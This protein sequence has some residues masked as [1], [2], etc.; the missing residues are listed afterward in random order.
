[1]KIITK[2]ALRALSLSI[3]MI[4]QPMLCMEKK[5]SPRLIDF[6]QNPLTYNNYKTNLAG[7]IELRKNA[8]IG[9]GSK[10]CIK[11]LK[12]ANIITEQRWPL[13]PVNVFIPNPTTQTKSTQTYTNWTL[14]TPL[15]IIQEINNLIDTQIN[16]EKEKIISHYGAEITPQ[17]Q[18]AWATF[19]LLSEQ[20]KNC[21]KNIKP[22]V[23]PALI[24]V[25]IL[26][27][28]AIHINLFDCCQTTLIFNE[29]AKLEELLNNFLDIPQASFTLI[30]PETTSGINL[31][32]TL[33]LQ[34][35]YPL[36]RSLN[37]KIKIELYIQTNA[38]NKKLEKENIM[39]SQHTWTPSNKMDFIIP[40]IGIS[41]LESH[42]HGHHGCSRDTF[43]NL[44]LTNELN[45]QAP[46]TLLNNRAMS[47]KK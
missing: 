26:L 29:H 21:A 28:Q 32:N 33:T 6:I 22:L 34:N 27:S 44:L 13:V 23:L 9:Y 46:L 25:H 39:S 4:I 31:L 38:T 15:I 10:K 35:N 5:E 36:Y 47:G 19:K 7:T 24:P 16:K 2:K 30:D 40:E 11:A 1:M 17:N 41:I 42:V 45:S 8:L 18:K 20:I 37:Q 3:L 14:Q 12:K 43:R